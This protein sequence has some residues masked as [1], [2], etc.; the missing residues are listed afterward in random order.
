M[1]LQEK[2]K[3]AASVE[4]G[5]NYVKA[6][7][8]E[9]IKG[10]RIGVMKSLL[11]DSLYRSAVEQMSMQGAEIVEFEARRSLLITS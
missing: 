2:I 11:T 1:Q 7:S 4:G 5:K 9:G 8:A 6:L 10:K 3:D